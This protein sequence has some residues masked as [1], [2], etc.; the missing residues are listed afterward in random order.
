MAYITTPDGRSILIP[1]GMAGMFG[2]APPP[3]L[4]PSPQLAAPMLPEAPIP[5]GAPLPSF[6]EPPLEQAPEPEAEPQLIAPPEPA[7]T[8]APAKAAP[9]A[10]AAPATPFSEAK[11]TADSAFTQQEE[12][13]AAQ[14]DIQASQ[15]DATADALEQGIASREALQAKRDAQAAQDQ[16][17]IS[18]R[19]S[20]MDKAVQS[21]ADYKI[22]EG[23][24]WRNASTGKKIGAAIGVALSALGDAL[25]GKSG[26]NMALQMITDSIRQ[27]VQ[28]QM[29]ERAQLGRKV[30]T[31]KSSLDNY[32]QISQDKQTQFAMKMAEESERTAKQIEL[33]AQRFSS[34]L[35]KERAAMLAGQLRQSKGEYL[36]KAAAD[37]WNRG[38][39][40]RSL[41]ESV[42]A[43]K[44]SNSLGYAGLAEQRAGRLQSAA[45]FREN[46]DLKKIELAQESLKLAQAGRMEE[47]KALKVQ[48]DE[49]AKRGIGAPN[50]ARIGEDG[51]P[52]I[53]PKTGLPEVEKGGTLMNKDG[54][55]F[56][57]RTPEEGAKLAK[58]MAST[59]DVT[60]LMNNVI[61]LRDKY[62]WSS[63]LFQSPEWQEAQA[64]WAQIILEKK[65]IDELGVIAGPDMDLMSKALG[66]KDPTQYRDPTAGI[67]RGRDN[68]I[69]KLN[70]RLRSERY[71]GPDITFVDTSTPR[72]G[73]TEA[74]RAIGRLSTPVPE[75]VKRPGTFGFLTDPELGGSGMFSNQKSVLDTLS[76]TANNYEIPEAQRLKAKKD[77]EWAAKKAATKEMREYAER[78]LLTGQTSSNASP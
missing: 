2:Q 28:L 26:P 71:N 61:H 17:E 10:P 1:D 16:A 68:G 46:L 77:L 34:P 25:Q 11:A 14:G 42:A 12:A 75:G 37:D 38:L 44:A 19:I 70:T 48:S 60:R 36:T 9:T 15:A 55:P 52:V 27:D 33:T 57:A 64:D 39:Q 7:Q 67:K 62:G 56:L 43:R 5:T 66:A 30:Q 21:E 18:K 4:P 53:D 72:A 76:R 6:A 49:V 32:R 63:D 24:R 8:K 29:D 73:T 31:Q 74:D 59:S 54:T 45:Q 65:N 22:D 3:L 35:A 69:V 23:R 78:A 40:E 50:R 51:K 58:M 47:A 20:V 41:A 13:L